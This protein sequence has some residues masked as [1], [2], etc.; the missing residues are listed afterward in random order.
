MRRHS[1]LHRI[2]ERRGPQY[3]GEVDNQRNSQRKFDGGHNY[4]RWGLQSSGNTAAVDHAANNRDQPGGYDRQFERH[5][6]AEQSPSQRFYG[7]SN[8]YP[9]GKFFLVVT[10]KKFVSGAVVSLGEPYSDTVCLLNRAD[11]DWYRD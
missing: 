4:C 11:R 2:G 9:S 1:Q 6:H 8:G 10:G 5:Y 7:A 3:C